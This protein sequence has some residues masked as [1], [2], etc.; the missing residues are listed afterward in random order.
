ME[1][2]ASILFIA[3]IVTSPAVGQTAVQAATPTAR[4]MVWLKASPELRILLAEELGEAGASRFAR[5][6]GWET[7]MD[8]TNKAI[9]QGLDGVC[10]SPDGLVHVIEAKGGTSQL[11]R[12]YGYPQG[13]SEWA[14]KASE[15]VLRS[16]RATAVEREAVRSVLKAARD[17]KLRVHTIRTKHI[18]GEPTVTVLEKTVHGT[19][20]AARLARSVVDKRGGEVLRRLAKTKPGAAGT[21]PQPPRSLPIRRPAKPTSLVVKVQGT[22]GRLLRLLKSLGFVAGG[23]TLAIDSGIAW[24]LHYRGQINKSEL[25]EKIQDA[26]VR[27]TAV[28]VAVQAVYFV[29]A[30]PGGLVVVGVA[31]VSYVVADALISHIRE[32]YGSRHVTVKDLRGIAPAEFLK[33]LQCG[34]VCDR[35]YS[36]HV[37]AEDLRGIAPAGFLSKLQGR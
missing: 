5:A 14:V 37:T 20:D 26:T 31:V 24:G 30:T 11:G 16:P 21:K 27:A 28:G 29:A 17:G 1:R 6:K 4:Q 34:A 18:L 36:Q 12:G 23:M 35:G 2:F 8:G 22:T 25:A 10:R 33:K 7:I 32:E 9:R 13:S 15:R 3:M 19:D